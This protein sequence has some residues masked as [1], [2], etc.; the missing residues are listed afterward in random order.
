MG[1]LA[2]AL[3][4]QL[5]AG[6]AGASG[7][8]QPLFRA[9]DQKRFD[10]VERWEKVFDD[11]ERD[12]WQR[13]GHVV[14]KLGLA[15]GARVA[16]LGAGTGYFVRHLAAA[17]GPDGAVYAV[18][19]EPKMVAHLRDRADA[20]GTD[21]VTPLLASASNPRLPAASLDV[22]LI[23]DT[24]HHL[25]GRLDYLQ[26]LRRALRPSGRIAIVD[27]K[28]KSLPVGPPMDH[29]IAREQVVAEM[30]AAGY[31]LS[32]ESAELPY[33]YFLIFSTGEP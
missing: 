24:F 17:V 19:I 28:K 26:R 14:E 11:P 2:V 20:E 23:V 16:D 25:D 30:E 15:P 1:L 32:D 10:D 18:D 13:P 27:W 22:I 21:N 7:P 3:T 5:A 6:V 31:R 12:R 33:Q 9:A 8:D 29:K 4:A